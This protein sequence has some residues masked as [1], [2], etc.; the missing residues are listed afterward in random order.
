MKGD[1]N[2]SDGFTLYD[3][4]LRYSVTVECRNVF[5]ETQFENIFIRSFTFSAD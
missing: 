1:K 5:R 2:L 3:N 4:G